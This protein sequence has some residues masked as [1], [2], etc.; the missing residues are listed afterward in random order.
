MNLKHERRIPWR[1]FVPGILFAA[2][3][4][5][6]LAGRAEQ[7]T[8]A[9]DSLNRL[10]RTDYGNGTVI[11]YAYDAAGNILSA[12]TITPFEEIALAK[13]FN[14]FSYPGTVPPQYATCQGLLAALGT[15]EE[16]E[17]LSR[18]NVVNQQ[19]ERCTIGGGI[20]FAIQPGEGY[21]VETKVATEV[22]LPAQPV[23]PSVNLSAGLNLIG[24]PSPKADLTCFGFLNGFGANTV[25]TIQRFNGMTGRFESCTW[26]QSG[27]AAGMDFQ[28]VAGEGYFLHVLTGGNL[29]L[30]GCKN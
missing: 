25:A 12:V 18:F 15:T 17:S 16:V 14:L 2:L 7:I 3:M 11:E 6:S 23:C 29:T 8:N 26:D 20:N 21:L 22:I 10:I 19:F 13:G 30:P 9:Y 5:N 28:I 24:H 27:Q 4:M 1:L